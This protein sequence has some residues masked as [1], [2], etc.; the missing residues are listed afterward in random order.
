MNQ[1]LIEFSEKFKLFTVEETENL[2]LIL[3]YNTGIAKY[4]RK[5]NSI[6]EALRQY[7]IDNDLLPDLAQFWLEQDIN[8]KL[9][10]KNE[11]K[12]MFFAVIFLCLTTK[13]N[14]LSNEPNSCVEYQSIYDLFDTSSGSASGT[15][16][17]S[18][19]CPP[20]RPKP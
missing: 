3:E 17:S 20:Q 14:K 6:E 15:S 10:N 5:Y 8:E 2:R 16:G 9:Q 18:S 4:L 12:L 7:L 1:I 19:S 11:F 13:K